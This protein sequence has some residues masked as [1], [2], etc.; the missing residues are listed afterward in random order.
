[1]KRLAII[2]THPIQY[3]A[4]FFKKLAESGKVELMVYYTWA[5]GAGIK[6]DPDFGKAFEWDIPLLEGYE[7]TLV[8][9]ISK[10]PGSH[11]YRGIVC[12]TLVEQIKAWCPSVILVYGW[13]FQAHLKVM[14]YFKGKI[15]VWFR[16][17]STLLDFDFRTIKDIFLYFYYNLF[18]FSARV[19]H[20]ISPFIIY[21]TYKIR[22]RYLTYIYRYIDTAFFV[23]TY[24]KLYFIDNGLK[25]EQLIYLPHTV[26]N[27]FFSEN[28]EAREQSA[29]SMRRSLSIADDNFVILFAGKF[30]PR[31]NPEVLVKSIIEL[32]E[33][34]L[35]DLNLSQIHLIMV[36]NGIL[37]EH[38][39]I[40]T[41]NKSYIH[42]LPFQ[43]QSNMPVIYRLG[44]VFC[45]PSQSETWGL[46][47]NEALACGRKLIVSEKVGGAIDLV[48]NGQN[49]W[50][51]KSNQVNSLKQIILIAKNSN[52]KSIDYYL[53]YPNIDKNVNILLNI[54]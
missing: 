29:L 49:G 39:K 2:T 17:D 10:K 24:N 5:Q 14:Q 1:M 33:N 38:L 31:K 21:F 45:L 43:N 35:S 9:N 7:Y 6:H 19:F 26:N 52:L 47:L 13:N 40:L 12:P 46:S 44:N 41:L 11:H 4:P 34:N 54:L 15:P 48:V 51:F 32:N 8:K 3:N 42:F 50:I 36:G 37:E 53:P 27:E 28:N 30:E 18:H 25:D 16:G 23:G 20:P 22:N